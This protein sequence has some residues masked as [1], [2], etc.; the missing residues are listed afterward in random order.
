LAVQAKE[1]AQLALKIYPKDNQI[2]GLLSFRGEEKNFQYNLKDANY[3]DGDTFVVYGDWMPSLPKG[4]GLYMYIY[5]PDEYM[6]VTDSDRSK[7]TYTGIR[8]EFDNPADDITLA[9]SN[10][11]MKESVS[12]KGIDISTYFTVKNRMHTHVYFEKIKELLDL[13]V[14]RLG[15][16]PY[17]SFRVVEVPY[18]VGHALAG[19]TF[20]SGRIIGMPFMTD[21]SL[22]HELVHQWLGVGVKPDYEGG[23]WAEGLTTYYADR[24]FAYAENE[25]VE[26]RK[27]ALEAYMAHAR[28][29]EPGTCLMDF[30]ANTGK[31]SQAIGYGKSMMVFTMLEQILGREDFELAV[32]VFAQRFMHKVAD[33]NDI[34]TIMED[35]SG[36]SLKGFLDGWLGETALA[37]FDIKDIKTLR[38]LDG[39]AVQFDVTNRYEWLEY[40][41]EVV[42]QTEDGEETHEFLYIKEEGK[43]ADIK[44][45]SRPVKLT[46]DPDYKVARMLTP[47]EQSPSLHNLF[48]KY[49]KVIF[50]NPA[51]RAKYSPYILT[52]KQAEVVSDEVNPSMYTDSNMIFLGSDNKAFEKMYG[53]PSQTGETF[54]IKS[55]K[56]PTAQDRMSYLVVGDSMKNIRSAS[57]RLS[58]YG[59]Y[60]ELVIDKDGQID[61]KI[62]A[63][64]MGV[65][66]VIENKKRGV[67]VSKPLEINDIIAANPDAKVYLMGEK[68]DNF[69]HH[70]SQ[71][72]LIRRLKESGKD[73]AIGLEMFQRPFQM[74]LNMYL[75]GR[76]SQAEMLRKTEYY[77][78]W[79]FDFRLYKHIVDYA[80]AHRIQMIALNM[81]E[82]ITKTVAKSG[83]PELTDEQGADLPKIVYTG[84]KY[85]DDLMQ[86][87]KM[88]EGGRKFEN[89][90]QAQLIWDETM[91]DS[92]AKYIAGHPEKTLVVLAGN[93]HVR[94]KYG[95]A[96]RITRRTGSPVLAILQ[97]ENY[98]EGIADYILYPDELDFVPSPKIGVMVDET[99]DGLLVK[100]VMEGSIAEKAGVQTEDY[101]TDFNGEKIHNL[102]DIKMALLYA[103]S[104]ITY[105]MFVRRDGKLARL[106][107]SF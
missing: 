58:H 59:K 44:L 70:D 83:I 90:Y 46:V 68:H 95:I 69:A 67:A 98:D 13:Y 1:Y 49:D 43:T 61:K 104:G 45:K 35:V 20:I 78:R 9:F 28:Q 86:I 97:D 55:Y 89:F 30:K 102:A 50:I 51:E 91:A 15:D 84:G 96:D 106:F 85:K 24:Y 14:A 19:M 42:V 60:S 8:Y 18:P 33:W 71:L 105:R 17:E 36:I 77:K 3:N 99:D 34:I 38:T 64:Q 54:M 73:V 103:D 47:A 39:W 72:E 88:H 41:L 100:Q 29:K 56:H 81:P 11:W 63:S 40:P 48:S 53:K 31:S 5:L 93:G 82:E 74:Y 10:R 4:V 7:N 27:N 26:Y 79:G 80:K 52:M 101:I 107:V 65:V 37:D 23:N 16:Y 87:F 32:R 2:T 66:K 92:A 57:Y 62:D 6:M 75:A 25:D 22:G 21:I 94:Y 76:L 12:Y